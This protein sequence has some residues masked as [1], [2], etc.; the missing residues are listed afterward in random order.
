M[1]W[2]PTSKDIAASLFSPES[3]ALGA[4]IAAAAHTQMTGP[5]PAFLMGI[6]AP[7]IVRGALSQSVSVTD[8][9]Q[10]LG[11]NIQDKQ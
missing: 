5:W 11:S 10:E 6:G 1:A 2:Q 9:K 3:P 7:S 4:L 8:P